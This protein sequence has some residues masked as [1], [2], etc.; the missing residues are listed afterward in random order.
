MAEFKTPTKFSDS[1]R[2]KR[3][4]NPQSPSTRNQNEGN[5]RSYYRPI[6]PKE[7][8]P[9]SIPPRR[10]LPDSIS[11]SPPIDHIVNKIGNRN[12][13][14]SFVLDFLAQYMISLIDLN[15]L[16]EDGLY[17]ITQLCQ[18]VLN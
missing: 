13:K 11:S 17:H 7:D 4:R 3:L 5:K 2:T 8:K 12:E 6:L 14:V 1:G 15:T 16:Y 18:Y 10:I 9:E